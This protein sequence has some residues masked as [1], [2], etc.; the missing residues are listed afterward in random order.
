MQVIDEINFFKS[1]IDSE[2]GKFDAKLNKITSDISEL[3]RND[4]TYTEWYKL[5]DVRL[6]SITNTCDRIESKFKVKNDGM[7][8]LS[9]LNINDHLRILKDH[10]SEMIN[11]TNQLSTH[12]AKSDSERQKLKNEIIANVEQIHRNYEPHIPRHSTPLNEK[13]LLLK[14]V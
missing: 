7:E 13:N 9:I 2:L 5:T 14:D 6:N 4:K 8:G 11:N 10:V 1:S 3:K 12:F